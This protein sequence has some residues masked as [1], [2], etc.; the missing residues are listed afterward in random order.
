MKRTN[1]FLWYV[2]AIGM[3]IG[4][5]DLK[6]GNDFL[7]KSPGVD[8][9]I[10]TIFSCKKY[11]ERVLVGAYGS[12][13]CGIIL[14]NGAIEGAVGYYDYN[15]RETSIGCDA[16]D[17]ITDIMSSGCAWGGV[18]EMYYAGGYAP[19]AENEQPHTKFSYSEKVNFV[20]QGIRRCYM[21]MRN[22]DRVPDMT[23]E[24]KT[25]RKAEAKLI[26]AI[27]YLHALRHIGGV[28]L[29]YD[30]IDASN[31]DADLSRKSVQEVL[32][33]ICD[34][35]DEAAEDL[36]W[37]VSRSDFG[38]MSRG[39]ALALKARA[40]SF[41]AS[42]LFNA[43]EPFLTPQEPSAQNKDKFKGNPKLVVW[44]GGY[45]SERWQQAADAYKAWIDENEASPEPYGLVMPEGNTYQDYRNAFSKCYADRCNGEVI[46]STGHVV[47]MF[48]NTYFGDYYDPTP[49]GGW[50]G[51][52][53]PLEYVNMFTNMDGTPSSYEDWCKTRRDTVVNGTTYHLG[54]IDDTP[55]LGKDPRLC[56]SVCIVGDKFRIYRVEPWIGGYHRGDISDDKFMSGFHVRKFLWDR[57]ADTFE[58]KPFCW[59]LMRVADIYLGYAEALNELGRTSEALVYLNKVRTR[60]GLPPMTT[61]LLDITQPDTKKIPH[62]DY[63]IGNDKLREEILDERAREFCLEESRWYDIARWKHGDILTK[64]LHGITMYAKSYSLDEP[65]PQNAYLVN[66]EKTYMYEI[67][68]SDPE[69]LFQ[70]IWQLN[71]EFDAKWYLSAMP[72]KEVNKGTG[73]TQN[74]GW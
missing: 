38:R 68:F 7:E 72:P 71:D 57:D 65:K 59:P 4:C 36:P 47:G 60:V 74:P 23:E 11:A 39:A 41:C 28:P 16:L 42:P 34:L 53:I 8:I 62:F 18:Y 63:L 19:P 44:L 69:P 17:A 73:L 43:P 45:S 35:C 22:V 55:F 61:D 31:S 20:W 12:L 5:Q 58:T 32:D 21:F 13:P 46:L 51:G 26:I 67:A 24:E 33:F 37:Q 9:T 40:L 14:W 1:K 70:R 29:L 3:L 10:D 30:A 52:N 6:F 54:N 48:G 50:G 2:L 15:R 25:L 27:N 49:D 64:R 66:G 56:E